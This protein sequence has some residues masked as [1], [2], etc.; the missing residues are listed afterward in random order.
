VALGFR[1]PWPLWS[2]LFLL[3]FVLAIRKK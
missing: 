2:A 3:A 1:S